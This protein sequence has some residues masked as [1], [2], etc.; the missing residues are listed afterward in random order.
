[1]SKT[2]EVAE[3]GRS[4]LVGGPEDRL[5]GEGNRGRFVAIEPDSGDFFLGDTMGEASERMRTT[6]PDAV[7][8]IGRIGF[9][10]AVGFSRRPVTPEAAAGQ[11]DAAPVG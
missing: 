3:R 7:G 6:Y 1:M 8:F 2:T 10:A 5:L 11:P 9:D 4:I